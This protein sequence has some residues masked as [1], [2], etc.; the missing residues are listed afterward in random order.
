M[1]RLPR[2]NLLRGGAAL[3][4][5]KLFAPSIARAG[6]VLGKVGGGGGGPDWLP[7]NATA[8]VDF[9]AADAASVHCYAGGQVVTD[10]NTQFAAISNVGTVFYPETISALGL[11]VAAG[12][13]GNPSS[14]SFIGDFLVAILSSNGSR[15][16]YTGKTDATHPLR[17]GQETGDSSN[18]NHELDAIAGSPGIALSGGVQATTTYIYNDADEID[19]IDNKLTY[20]AINTIEIVLSPTLQSI[21]VNG[22]DVLTAVPASPDSYSQIAIANTIGYLL[23]LQTI[24]VYTL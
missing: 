20:D 9:R 4:A 23:Y 24:T 3:A 1:L 8:Y 12:S 13:P 14:P 6:F 11:G 10:I 16:V 17:F 5:T 7:A 21:Q 19:F 22:G 18:Y 15:V 2:R